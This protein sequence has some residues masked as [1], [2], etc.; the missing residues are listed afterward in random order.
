M[1]P[2]TL[3]IIIINN[4]NKLQH[5][6]IRSVPVVTP[7]SMTVTHPTNM[8]PIYVAASAVTVTKHRK[9]SYRS[10]SRIGNRNGRS[11]FTPWLYVDLFG[12]SGAA[13]LYVMKEEEGDGSF[14]C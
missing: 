6:W 5:R 11:F 9:M 14:R 2:L 12:I 4:N 7:V 13:W 10:G 3:T 1:Q 8:D